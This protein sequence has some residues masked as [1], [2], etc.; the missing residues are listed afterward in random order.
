MPIHYPD[1][2][3]QRTPVR[4]FSYGPREAMLYALGI[5]FGND[6]LDPAELPFVY[7]KHLR[8]APT[9]ACVLSGGGPGDVLLPNGAPVP[10]GHRPSSF[11]Y[12]DMLH[13][14]EK[15]ELH[16]PLPTSGSFTAVDRVAAVYDKGE[17][18]GALIIRKTEWHLA[19][20]EHVATITT[21]LFC[22]AEGGFGGPSGGAPKPHPT[23][24]RP[25]DMSV[26]Y[27]TRPD[28]ALLYRLSGD[29]NPLHAE[30]AYARQAGFERP[31][32][33]GL[34]T[35][36]FTCRAVLAT[37]ADHDPD[38]ILSHQARFSA[39]VYPGDVISIDLWRDGKEIAFEAHVRA[40]GVTVIRNGLTVLR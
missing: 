35:F 36:G 39:I 1:V 30:P 2:L 18:K 6:P 11:S 5:G 33:H 4:P 17:G 20:G 22:R 25:P 26:D 15:I 14:E 3:D 29:A 9:A 27:P 10:S 8:I 12:P 19:S 28:Q 34:C 38:R 32:L 16:R 31:I 23:P 21:S 24:S 13:G 40:R 37:M 7:E